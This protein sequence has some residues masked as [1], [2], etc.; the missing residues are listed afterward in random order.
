MLVGTDNRTLTLGAFGS[1]GGTCQDVATPFATES[2][3]TVALGIRLTEPAHHQ[4]GECPAQVTA[5]SIQLSRPLGNRA[6]VDSVTGAALASFDEHRLLHPT[7]IPAGYRLLYTA[8]YGAGTSVG[9]TQHWESP[10]EIGSLTLTQ[11]DGPLTD[12]IKGMAHVDPHQGSPPLLVRGHP[13]TEFT[14]PDAIAWTE[15]GEAMLID[16]YTPDPPPTTASVIA[17]ADSSP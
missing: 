4:R 12:V 15:N 14:S 11:I 2:P 6:L 10:T 17:I 16:W 5:A 9:A 3:D 1:V 8:P 7:R 13:A